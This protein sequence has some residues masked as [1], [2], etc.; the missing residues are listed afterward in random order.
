MFPRGVVEL[1][2]RPAYLSASFVIFFET[3]PCLGLEFRYSAIAARNLLICSSSSVSRGC[4][5]FLIPE[6]RPPRAC[7]PIIAAQTPQGIGIMT[8]PNQLVKGLKYPHIFHID[9]TVLI[10][11]I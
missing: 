11:V 10:K 6:R 7:I 9:E 4:C 3:F 5:G 8:S 2:Y 1:W